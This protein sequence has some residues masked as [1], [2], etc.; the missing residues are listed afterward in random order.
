MSKIN[1]PKLTFLSTFALAMSLTSFA[2]GESAGQYV[3]DATITTKVKA[4]LLS[5]SQLKATNVSVTTSQG[6]VQL[7]GIVATRGQGIASHSGCEPD[8]WCQIG[9]GPAASPQYA[10]P[11]IH[12]DMAFAGPDRRMPC[13][14]SAAISFRLRPFVDRTL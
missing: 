6:V 4:A 5:D 10:K 14:F 3:D 11:V 9:S 8:Q 12:G 13:Y 2:Y 7:T 1:L